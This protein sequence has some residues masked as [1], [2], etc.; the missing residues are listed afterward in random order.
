MASKKISPVLTK[1]LDFLTDQYRQTVSRAWLSILSGDRIPLNQVFVMLDAVRRSSPR[2]LDE[3][4]LSK[5][6]AW[7]HGSAD[8][9]FNS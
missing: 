3:G 6:E 5:K 9:Q 4:S 8:T 2:P 1:T 7:K